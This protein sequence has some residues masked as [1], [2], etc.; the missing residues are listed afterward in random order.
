MEIAFFKLFIKGIMINTSS[1]S[2]HRSEE[3]PPTSNVS[4]DDFEE[5]PI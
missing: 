4:E 2:I 1:T 3:I 5:T